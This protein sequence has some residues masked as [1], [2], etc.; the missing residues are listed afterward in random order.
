MIDE[1]PGRT[2]AGENTASPVIGVLALQGAVS[3]HAAV[4]ATL[5]ARTRAVTRPEHLEGLA[6]L[7]MPGR[8]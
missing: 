5:G 8:N 4:L 7:V 3:E 6:G 1:T 2:P